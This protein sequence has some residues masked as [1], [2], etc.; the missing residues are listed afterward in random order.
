LPGGLAHDRLPDQG[1]DERAP[2]HRPR[3]RRIVAWTIALGN[4]TTEQID[5]FA[6]ASAVGLGAA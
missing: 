5:F 6:T 3:G 1:P 4:L 2:G